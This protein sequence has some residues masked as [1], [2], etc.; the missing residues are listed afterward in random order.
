ME[1][2][3]TCIL[4]E[5]NALA[6]EMMEEYIGLRDDLELLGTAIQRSEIQ[7]LLNRC[8]PSIVFLDLIIPYGERNDFSFLQFPSSSIFVTISGIP[9]SHYQGE[10]PPGEILELYKPISKEEFNRCVDI[11]MKKSKVANA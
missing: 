9:L 5:D 10:L 3:L 6:I 2:R 4:I 8:S 7:N 11:I 1:N